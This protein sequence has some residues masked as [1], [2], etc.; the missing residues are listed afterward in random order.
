LGHNYVTTKSQTASY[1]HDGY[2][3]S[4]CTKCGDVKVTDIV[5]RTSVPGFYNSRTPIVYS[6]AGFLGIHDWYFY[7]GDDSLGYVQGTN[8]LTTDEM[9]AWKDTFEELQAECDK[10]GISLVILVCPNKE[11]V[12][13]DIHSW[14]KEKV[15]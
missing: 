4:T 14:L 15:C 9:R 3:L 7:N 6:G 2:K 10:K 11:Q 1:A 12:Y 8:V 5:Y 13:Q